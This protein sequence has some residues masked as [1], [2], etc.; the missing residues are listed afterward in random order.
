V[1]ITVPDPWTARNIVIQVR[2]MAPHVPIVARS[3]YHVHRWQLTMAGAD[4]VVDEEDVVGIQI[5][6]EVRTR[7]EESGL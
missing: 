3:R 2:A 5:G 7:L 6:E 1:V 4:A